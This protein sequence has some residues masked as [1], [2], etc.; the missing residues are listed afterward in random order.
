MPPHDVHLLCSESWCS[1]ACWSVLALPGRI[2]KDISREVKFKV[3]GLGHG[4][5]LVSAPSSSA[6]F[7]GTTQL[8]QSIAGIDCA[9]S[10]LLKL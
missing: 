9:V 8:Q 1:C 7:I 2:S 6:D 3:L 4:A 5:A 10:T